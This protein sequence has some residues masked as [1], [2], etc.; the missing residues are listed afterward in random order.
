M[1]ILINLMNKSMKK[2]KE[3]YITN[4]VYTCTMGVDIVPG[5][6]LEF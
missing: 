3:S 5:C 2:R 1:T 6:D 4:S